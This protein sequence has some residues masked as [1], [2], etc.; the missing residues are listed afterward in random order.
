MSLVPPIRKGAQRFFSRRIGIISVFALCGL[1][2]RFSPLSF[3]KTP[4]HLSARSHANLNQHQYLD[5]EDSQ[6]VAPPRVTPE[7]P[8]LAVT[9]HPAQIAEPFIETATQGWHYN[10]PPPAR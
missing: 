1:V 2:T 7:T 4:V 6:W 3:E 5:H 10:R 9:P 8:R